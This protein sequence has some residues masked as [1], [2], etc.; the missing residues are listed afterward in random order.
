MLEAA[1]RCIVI[2]CALAGVALGQEV[3]ATITGLVTDPSGAPVVGATVVVTNVSQNVSLSV[4]T[5]ESGNYVTPFL[6]PGEYRLTVEQGGFKRFVRENIVLQ[7]QDKLRLDVRLEIGQL[8][9]SITVRE[10][11]SLLQTETATRSQVI[12]NELI[13]QLPT[14]GRNPFQLAWASAGVIKSGDWRYLR[15]F[16]IGGTSGVS[17]NGGKNKENE[18]LLDGISN[19]RGDRTVIHVPTMDSAACCS[20]I[21]RM[22]S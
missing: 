3:R 15:S 16:D 22:T 6:A 1:K 5:N 17:I 13:S 12:A 11:V 10:S 4:T 21:S 20:S 2:L 18:V 19:V 7:T 8:T 14:Q 9:E